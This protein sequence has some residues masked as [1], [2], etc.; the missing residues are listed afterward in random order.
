MQISDSRIFGNRGGVSSPDRFTKSDG[1]RTLVRKLRLCQSD[2][3]RNRTRVESRNGGAPSRKF[4]RTMFRRL[5]F[6]KRIGTVLKVYG[7]V[8][9]LKELKNWL[10]A[11][12]MCLLN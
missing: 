4:W 11:A 1:I 3:G 10:G 12:K 9:K 8:E 7:T 5:F 6:G 2:R